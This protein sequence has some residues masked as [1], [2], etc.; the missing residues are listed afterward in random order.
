MNDDIKEIDSIIFGIFS[1]QEI[2]DMSV[3]KIDSTKLLGNGTVYDERMGSS[4]ENNRNCVTCDMTSKQCPGHFGHIEFNEYIIHPL[5]YKMVV[6]FLKCFCIQCN[7]LLITKDQISLCGLSKYKLD[8]RFKKLMEKLEKVDICCHCSHPQPKITYTTIDNTI[9]MIYKDTINIP[10]EENEEKE[11]K[12]DN[13]ISIVLTVD[14]IKKM[15]DE[16]LDEDVILCGFNPS[17]IHPR[18]LIISVFP[19]LPPCARPFVLAEGNIC[20]DDLTNQILEIIKSNNILKKD[21]IELPDPKRDTKRQKALQSLKFRVLTFYNNCLAPETP[22]IMW[23]GSIKRADEIKEGDNIIGDDGDM[24]TVQTICEGEDYMYKVS[25]HKGDDYIVNSN[26]ILTLKYSSHKSIFWSN[27]NNNCPLG[28]W[29]MRWFDKQL[30]KVK[31]KSISV[32][33]KFNKEESFKIIKSFSDTI[34][35][36][37][38]VDIPIKTYLKL[39]DTIKRCFMGFK[40][41]LVNWPKQ[42]VDLDP[43][44]LGMWLGDGNR[45]GKGFT[46]ADKEL[47]D[48][49]KLWANKNDAEVVLHPNKGKKDIYFGIKSKYNTDTIRHNL[50]PLKKSLDRYNLVNNKHIPKEFLIN[51]RETRLKVLAGMIDTDGYSKNS[52]IEICQGMMHKR[53][54]D[55]L[56]FL[57]KSLGFST[58]LTIKDTTW[59]HNNIKKYGK[60]YR[61]NISGH[62]SYDIPV[63][64][65]RKIC[66]P[67]ISRNVLST[68][69]QVSSLGIGKYNGFSI[70]KNQRFLFNDFTVTHNSAG[71]AKHPTNNRPIKGL[72]ERLTGKEG[73]IRNNLMGKRVEFSGRTVIGPDPNLPFGWLG[74]PKEIAM[75]LTIP[76]RVT[77]FNKKYLSDIVNNNKANFVITKNKDNEETRLNLKYSLY[78][79]GTKLL[80]NDIVIRNGQKIHIT[81]QDLALQEGDQVQRNGTFLQPF[82]KTTKDENNVNFLSYPQKKHIELNL[83]DE[84]HRHLI[85]GDTVLLNRQP[86]LHKGSMLA[87]KIKVMSGKTIRMNLS[88]TKT[89]NADFDGDEMNIHVPQF[90][91]SRAEL[92]NLSATK[93]NIISAQA[94]KP[95]IVIVQDSLLG[96][97]EMTRDNVTMSQGNFFDISMAGTINGKSLWS[98]KKMNT[99]KKVLEKYGKKVELYTGKSLFSLLLPE[100]LIYE[101]NNKSNPNE[102]IVKIYNGVMY[103]GTLDKMILGASHNSIIQ[104]LN[105]EYGVEVTSEFISNIQFITNQW[106]VMA[107]FS[108]GLEDCLITNP[109]NV[110]KIN[111]N[112]NKCYIEAKGIEETTHNPGIR[113]V[114]VT[115]ALNKAKDIGMRISKESM[116]KNNNLISTVKSGSKGDFFN[117][118]QL[119]GLLGQQNL[120]GQRVKPTLNNSRRTLPHYPF[121]NMS[122]ELEYESRGFVRHSFIEGLNP[123]EFYFHSMSG[124]EGICDKLLCRKQWAAMLVVLLLTWVNSVKQNQSYMIDITC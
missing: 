18:N 82:D 34:T 30:M 109:N 74:L 67:P 95:N 9:S 58:N 7:R 112:L 91:E 29:N 23:N 62:T 100:D 53:I 54:I 65:K 115:A 78:T 39:P 5:F 97:Y 52:N 121:E 90:L 14:E 26:H 10:N 19:V 61:L 113:E 118:A 12:K 20:D 63:L 37:D 2:V 76:E 80:Y 1:P 17:R 3:C 89:F 49:W 48:Y 79:K 77:S 15:F 22:I 46:C 51:D 98:V 25:Q 84:V 27:S 116:S 66:P 47:V 32:T 73:Q 102:P 28:S 4:L 107:G 71:K 85:D 124:R 96:A 123:Q 8:I 88:T 94:S 120:L 119:T 69:I 44:L 56:I 11:V 50:N 105:K 104:V 35:D 117:I 42:K 31:N 122:K 101:K 41:S 59:S 57:C 110:V 106:L 81:N 21:D 64:L 83:G 38:I 114:R 6:S 92:E 60:A 45:S 40:C 86:T 93:Y 55:D 75:E 36:D 68:T 43:Y 108:I 16:I 70:D 103:E 111:D 72:K 24:R 13:K 87:K 33:K 99:I